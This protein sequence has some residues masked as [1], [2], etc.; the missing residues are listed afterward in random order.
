MKIGMS[1]LGS[2]KAPESAGRGR[3][4]RSATGARVGRGLAVGVGM[5]LLLPT[6]PAMAATPDDPQED[7]PG[8]AVISPFFAIGGPGYGTTDESVGW[9][10]GFVAPDGSIVYCIEPGAF[11]PWGTSTDGGWQDGVVS[12]SPLGSR[13]LTADEQARIGRIVAEYGQTWDNRESSAVSFAVKAVANPEAMYRSHSYTGAHNLRDY[14]NWIL[15]SSEGGAEARAVAGR[16]QAIL[17]ATAGTTAGPTISSGVLSFAVDSTNNYAGTAWLDVPGA[18]A[19]ATAT[20]TLTN[21]IFVATGTNTLVST[22][23]LGTQFEVRGVAPDD[24]SEYKISGTALINSGYSGQLHVWETGDKQK[25]AGPGS[26]SSYTAS[27]FDPAERSTVFQPEA[28]SSAPRFA[29]PGTPLKDTA[30]F[31]IAAD[32]SGRVNEWFRNSRGEHAP[33]EWT[34]EAYAVDKAPE[35]PT[36]TVPAGAELIASTKYSTGTE[37][38][39]AAG[40]ATFAEGEVMPADGRA[41]VYVWKFNAATQ[42]VP[43]LFTEGYLWTDLFGLVEETTFGVDVTTKAQVGTKKGATSQ[44]TAIVTGV[45]PNEGLELTFEKYLVPTVQDAS[46][47]WVPNAPAGTEPGDLSWVCTAD[48]LIGDNL[49]APQHITKAGEYKSP[50]FPA[51]EYG[52]ELWVE[53]LQTVPGEE[54]KSEVVDRGECGEPSETSH[55][56]DV[57]TQ[58]H[59]DSGAGTSKRG[60]QLWDTAE[61]RGS[62]PKGAT[63]TFRAYQVPTGSELVCTEKTLVWTSQPVA[64]EE[65]LYKDDVQL[66]SSGKFTPPSKPAGMTTTFVETTNT[67]D[68]GELS[69]GEC[70][71]PSETLTTPAA[72][73]LAQTGGDLSPAWVAAGGSLVAVGLAAYLLP[74]LRRRRA[75]K[76]VDAPNVD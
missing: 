48:N 14:V 65:G 36:N 64:L 2:L 4:F 38:P 56:I 68:G 71:E 9:Q 45:L 7:S 24:G 55:V 23:P 21:G 30:T 46:G 5:A 70:G 15:F 49:D 29:K 75:T 41:V 59:S 67:E 39:N 22:A 28:T 31:S 19:G 73:N 53:Q 74:T 60:D 25:T 54:G 6:L 10:G 27:G 42:P 32:E 43:V 69:K 72:G 8:K 76:T 47:K 13:T 12:S 62:V 58:A 63:V 3:A 16:A 44:D 37:G 66:A 40:T 57:K 35:K 17:D 26:A 33:T 1:N 11:N 51:D 52:T 50:E 61:I 18:P 20:L 34:I